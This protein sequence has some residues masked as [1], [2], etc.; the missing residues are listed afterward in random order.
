M[1]VITW[2]RTVTTAGTAVRLATSS[3]K[4]RKAAIKALSTNSGIVYVG[5]EYNADDVQSSTGWE[6]SAKESLSLEPDTKTGNSTFVDLYDIWV[7]AASNGD[8]VCVA[9]GV[10][11][12]FPET[13]PTA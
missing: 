5:K 6:L 7:D 11:E 4:V 8:K 12:D 9:V 1:K 3:F 2:Q 10:T 13:N